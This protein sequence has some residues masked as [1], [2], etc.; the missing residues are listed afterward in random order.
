MEGLTDLIGRVVLFM[1]SDEVF[2][3]CSDCNWSPTSVWTD[4]SIKVA[5]T[6]L[7]TAEVC[8]YSQF[9]DVSVLRLR[10]KRASEGSVSAVKAVKVSAKM[11]RGVGRRLANVEG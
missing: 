4:G 1:K 11:S 5:V 6:W 7:A 10:A 9:S 2:D 3:W 8:K